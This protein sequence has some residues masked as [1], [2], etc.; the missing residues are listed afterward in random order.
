MNFYFI[1]Q[2]NFKNKI[3]SLFFV[4]IKIS[5][6]ALRLKYT[7]KY[8]QPTRAIVLPASQTCS[9]TL[10]IVQETFFLLQPCK[11]ILVWESLF[12]LFPLPER[13]CSSILSQLAPSFHLNLS[14]NITTSKSSFQSSLFKCSSFR[15]MQELFLSFPQ[16]NHQIWIYLVNLCA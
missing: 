11:P 2:G 12:L 14:S 10:L 7:F 3:V 1:R 4:T 6:I 16:N 13:Q 5:Y 15:L 8:S 9:H